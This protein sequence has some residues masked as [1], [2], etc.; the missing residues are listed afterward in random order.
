MKIFEDNPFAQ[1]SAEEERSILPFLFYEPGYYKNLLSILS[2][3]ASR[4]ILGQRGDGKSYIIYKLFD[5]LKEKGSLPILITNYDEIPLENNENHFLGII[6]RNLTIELSKAI[7]LDKRKKKK[8]N[9][10]YK[11]RLNFYIK[12][13]YNGTYSDE[14]I[15]CAKVIQSQKRKNFFLRIYNTHFVTILNEIIN[16]GVS[17]GISGL[18]TLLGIPPLEENLNHEYLKEVKLQ[19]LEEY[20]LQDIA[21]IDLSNLKQILK[22]LC[23]I[24]HILEYK[25]IVFLFDRIDE[26]KLINGDIARI[27]NF[28]K[29][30]LTDTDLLLSNNVS[31]VFSLWSEIKKS[32]NKEGV[33]FDKF[34]DI[35]VRLQNSDLIDL[36]NLRL[37][38]FS[39]DKDNPVRFNTLIPNQNDRDSI[40]KIANHSPRTLVK[41][42]GE[43]YSHQKERDME[44]F[45][46]TAVSKGLIDFCKR[47]DFESLSPLRSNG[48][49]SDI[50]DWIEK[51]LK[52][53]CNVL[54]VEELK[55]NFGTNN[56]NAI[57]HLILMTNYGLLKKTDELNENANI[58]FKVI[59]PRVLFLL[60]R[61]ITSLE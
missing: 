3:N 23:E 39:S 17:L 38:F 25:S 50:Y 5:D 49:K 44:S 21:S 53:R 32:L 42:L 15:E 31:I 24:A 20:S 48:K 40:I 1:Y 47:F 58:K 6:I 22:T 34:G 51:I 29:G 12:L 61:G 54:T 2:N 4:F 59:E 41:L 36:L 43:I 26:F 33:R 55:T 11:N 28:C 10:Y 9:E 60:S 57:S 30:I 16:S 46:D 18:R 56:K 13:F 14:F 52:M 37:W 35:D 7:I 19:D 45:E 8:L 27:T